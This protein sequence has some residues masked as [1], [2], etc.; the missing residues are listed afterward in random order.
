MSIKVKDQR[1]VKACLPPRAEMPNFGLSSHLCSSSI[2]NSSK[3][4]IISK[5]FSTSKMKVVNQEKFV[6]LIQ[7]LKILKEA[8]PNAKVV[9]YVNSSV[10]IKAESDICCTSANAVNVVKNLDAEQII[11]IPDKNLGAYIQSLVLSFLWRSYKASLLHL[12]AGDTFPRLQH[13]ASG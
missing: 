2:I 8:N 12:S 9:T 3:S 11:F 13:Q 10:E 1:S 4:K 5:S 6:E 7:G